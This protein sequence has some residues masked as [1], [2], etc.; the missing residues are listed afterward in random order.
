MVIQDWLAEKKINLLSFDSSTLADY[1]N[2]PRYHF[3][4]TVMGFTKPNWH[5]MFGAAWHWAMKVMLKS[6]RYDAS[7]LTQAVT[8]FTTKF[9]EELGAANVGWDY[10]PERVTKIKDPGRVLDFLVEYA[11]EHKTDQDLLLP[12]INHNMLEVHG[13]VPI[14]NDKLMYYRLDAVAELPGDCATVIDHKTGTQLSSNWAEQWEHSLQI[15]LYFYVMQSMFHRWAKAL[16][17]GAIFRTNDSTYPRCVVTKS[18]EQ[19]ELW[20]SSVNHLVK[21]LEV[22]VA[23]LNEAKESDLVMHCFY[24]TQSG[25]GCSSYGGCRYNDIC[26]AWTNPLQH[27]NEIPSGYIVRFWDP[28][29]T[30]ERIA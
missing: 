19:L 29:A 30:E 5:L 27:L 20:L 22:D 17:N 15:T 6:N 24:P 1:A 7:T 16:I 13:S 8:A 3:F 26:L 10:F 23:M 11:E 18:I 4:R 12:Y 21:Q 9:T 2:C 14:A 28:R 25:S